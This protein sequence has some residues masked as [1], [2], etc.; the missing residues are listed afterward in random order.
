MPH[1]AS[2]ANAPWYTAPVIIGGS[3]GS[4]TRGVAL[5]LE[6]LGV[7]MACISSDFL[8]SPAVGGIGSSRLSHKASRSWRNSTTCDLKCNPAAD[9]GIISS[10][11][12]GKAVGGHGV[13]SWLRHNSS[14]EHL[15]DAKSGGGGGTGRDHSEYHSDQDPWCRISNEAGLHDAMIRPAEICGGSKQAA[16]QRLREAVAPQ[17]QRPLR[18]GLKNPH[19]TYYVNVLRRIFPCMVF[20][21]TVRD[22]DVMVRT[23]K[24]FESRVQEAV[25]YGV[26]AESSIKEHVRSSKAASQRFYGSYLRR[27]NGGLHRW[28]SRC[29]P[30]RYAHVPLQRLIVIGG[31]REGCFDSIMN[32][33]L[34]ALRI[35]A[36]PDALNASRHFLQKS[37]PTVRKS[38]AEASQQ[39]LSLP[40]GD[41]ALSWPPA[42]E[43]VACRGPLHRHTALDAKKRKN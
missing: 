1:S 17:H 4:G 6:T 10:F 15:A 3:G 23:A 30:H 25:R 8:I 11:R 31:G 12:T 26:L 36:T 37:L 35:E 5:L 24:H 33:L 28:L 14:R 7:A 21:N 2:C 9:C 19:A 34:R 18:W 22:L 16:I 13:L 20:V 29:M 32:P 27:V 39:P 42:L 43:S 41:D 40:R 38:L